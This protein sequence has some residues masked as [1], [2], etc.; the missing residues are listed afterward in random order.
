MT[1]ESTYLPIT[2][3]SHDMLLDIATR[4]VVCAIVYTDESG[5]ERHLHDRIADVYTLKGAE[6]L[7]LAG[8]TVIRLDRLV[9]VGG[10]PV[11]RAAR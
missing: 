5:A 3:S 4:R 2:C 6:Y 11:T 1:Q 9:S 7:R 10:I 8:N